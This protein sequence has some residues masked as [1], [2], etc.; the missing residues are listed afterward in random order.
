MKHIPC[1][2]LGPDVGN[3]LIIRARKIKLLFRIGGC[4]VFFG[5]IVKLAVVCE[6]AACKTQ[7]D[8]TGGKFSC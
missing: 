7:A 1:R 4:A 3:R 5:H 6:W 8:Q 2:D